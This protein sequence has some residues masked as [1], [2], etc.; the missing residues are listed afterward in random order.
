MFGACFQQSVPHTG[1]LT[2]PK[3]SPSAR[4]LAVFWF[5]QL[6]IDLF[7]SS[8]S[9]LSLPVYLSLV[10]HD[11]ILFGL[12]LCSEPSSLKAKTPVISSPGFLFWRRPT[13][14]R[15]VAVLPSGLQRFTSVF[16]MGTGGTTTLLSPEFCTETSAQ[17]SGELKISDCRCKFLVCNIGDQ[18]SKNIDCKSSI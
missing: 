13:L 18:F 10:S 2:L 14:A 12:E 16:G 5:W 7:A 4:F 17:N 1:K 6:P 15:P 9:L 11:S 8:H 3:N